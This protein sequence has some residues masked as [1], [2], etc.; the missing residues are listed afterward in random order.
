MLCL[1]L[2]ARGDEPQTKRRARGIGTRYSVGMPHMPAGPRSVVS[3]SAAVTQTSI[4]HAAT[5]TTP[6]PIFLGSCLY[7]AGFRPFETQS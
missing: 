3:S 5:N 2:H 6:G 7:F 1:H 4:F